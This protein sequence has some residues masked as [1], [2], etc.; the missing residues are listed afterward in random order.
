MD[1]EP[2]KSS[3]HFLDVMKRFEEKNGGSNEIP[4]EAMELLKKEFNLG[5]EDSITKDDIH[6]LL[7]ETVDAEDIRE[8]QE[9]TIEAEEALEYFFT[10][11]SKTTIRVVVLGDGG[12]SVVFGEKYTLEISGDG[13]KFK[14]HGEEFINRE[15]L[16]NEIR[17]LHGLSK[18][19]EGLEE[20]SILENPE[21]E[22]SENEPT[23]QPLI[24]KLKKGLNTGQIRKFIEDLSVEMSDR[25]FSSVKII[26]E[27]WNSD[28]KHFALI[29]GAK[30][31]FARF[32][33]EGLLTLLVFNSYMDAAQDLYNVAYGKGKS[34][35]KG[36]EF[37]AIDAGKF[38]KKIFSSLK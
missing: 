26:T 12:I 32:A 15:E 7:R 21:D 2:Y 18:I 29:P 25:R 5:P 20:N 35:A 16:R 1:N 31:L 8:Y 27:D 4:K 34:T 3:S 33:E 28:F 6:S 37:K 10:D 13:A 30:K 24:I 22:N 11:I 36:I 23:T 17:K 14:I 19:I 9:M 38:K